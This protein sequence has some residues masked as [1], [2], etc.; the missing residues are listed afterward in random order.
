MRVAR[1]LIAA[2]A[3]LAAAGAAMTAS[4]EDGVSADKIVLGQVAVL[5]GPAAAL[6]LGMQKGLMAAFAEANRAGGVNGRKIE[7][8]SVNDGYEP[9]QSI[10]ATRKLINDDKIFALIGS[11]GTPTSVA[12]EPI[13]A[14]AGVPLIGAFTGAEVLRNP[15]KRN[16]INVRASY[17]EETETMVA[18][19]TK[20]MGAKRIAIFYQDDAFGQAGLAGVTRALDKRGM[21]LVAEGTYERN[22]TA[23]KGALL[24][25]LK[26]SPDAVIMIGAYAPCAEFIRLARAT[27]LEAEFVNIS[28]VGSEA[29]VNALGAL[30]EGVAVTQVVPFPEDTSVPLV[31]E[32]QKALKALDA[33]AQPSFVSLEGYAAGRLFVTLLAQIPGEVTRNALIDTATKSH[34]IDLGGFKLTYGPNNNRGSDMVYLTVIRADGRLRPVETLA[35]F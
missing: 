35:G 27:K 5:E 29:L 13:A 19:L 32:Y 28:F 4:A 21:G 18:H 34:G 20:D 23:V 10:T 1:L 6:G 17:F 31:A 9:D 3:C 24:S 2:C 12:I 33:N 16:V 15:Y 30:G 7:L 11:V 22:T 26:G 25:I 14:E 8:I